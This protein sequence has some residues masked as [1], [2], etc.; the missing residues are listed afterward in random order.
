[1]IITK[2]IEITYERYSEKRKVIDKLSVLRYNADEVKL[3]NDIKDIFEKRQTYVSDD[4]KELAK[5]IMYKEIV[6][7][8][9][10]GFSL[11]N[12]ATKERH[13]YLGK[14][15]IGEIEL[16]FTKTE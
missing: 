8:N 12:K 4:A 7:A 16:I 9:S 3:I 2:F 15:Y 10:E 14:E 6:K 5:I 13:N 1:M 11:A